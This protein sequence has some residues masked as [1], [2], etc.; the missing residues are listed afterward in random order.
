MIIFLGG[1]CNQSTWRDK[2]I[3]HLAVD[4]FN[5]V[6]EHW[7][8][9]CYERE[10]IAR[11][12]ADFCLFVITPKIEGLFALAEVVDT[13]YKR[14]DRTIYCYLE[15][16]GDESFTEQQLSILEDIGRLVEGNGAVWLK[17]L[18]EIADFF[19]Q[20]SQIKP[21][22]SENDIFDV[23]I[24]YGRRH[25]KEFAVQ[26]RQSLIDQ[27]YKVWLDT[28]NIA[29]AVEFQQKIDEG[30]RYAH[31]FCF[32]LSPHSVNS[33]YCNR[34]LQTALAL[35][36]R[37]IPIH[38]MD[39]GASE[40]DIPEKLQKLNWMM[41]NSNRTYTQTLSMLV[42]ALNQH[43]EVLHPHCELLLHADKWVNS[44]KSHEH[45]LYGQAMSNACNW[46]TN[47]RRAKEL[48]VF[49]LDEH[50]SFINASRLYHQDELSDICVVH[51]SNDQTQVNK[52]CHSL[53][54]RGYVTVTETLDNVQSCSLDKLLY[55]RLRTATFIVVVAS[56]GI[57]HTSAWKYVRDYVQSNQKVSFTLLENLS[58]EKGSD[59]GQIIR[60]DA[61]ANNEE[62]CELLLHHLEQ[63]KD[64]LSLRNN[65]FCRAAQ[66]GERKSDGILLTN[67]ELVDYQQFLAIAQVRSTFG[68]PQSLVDFIEYSAQELEQRVDNCVDIFVCA[69]AEDNHFAHRLKRRLR[70]LE[71]SVHYGDPGYSDQDYALFKEM[72]TSSSRVLVVLPRQASNLVDSLLEMA[73]DLNKPITFIKLKRFREAK[74]DQCYQT[75]CHAAFEVDEQLEV[76]LTQ[77]LAKISG[78]TEYL[79]SYR[80]WSQ[81][82]HFWKEQNNAEE[83][84]LGNTE[85]I[86]ASAW[87]KGALAHANEP[88][89]SE[90]LVQFIDDSRGYVEQAKR[91]ER[92]N[93]TRL[94]VFSVLSLVL[95]CV[96]LLLG[97]NAVKDGKIA[98]AQTLAIQLK[99]TELEKKTEEANKLAKQA[100]LARL[101]AQEKTLLAMA[102]TELANKQKLR[103]ETERENAQKQKDLALILKS[104][105][106]R[107]QRAA[108]SHQAEAQNQADKALR[109]KQIAEIEALIYQAQIQNEGVERITLAVRA[110]KRLLSLNADVRNNILYN[111]L[112]REI[113]PN[114]S[115]IHAHIEPVQHLSFIKEK[116]SLLSIDRSNRFVSHQFTQR[117]GLIKQFEYQLPFKVIQLLSNEQRSVL[118]SEA[119]VVYEINEKEAK[120][121]L[122]RLAS[123]FNAERILTLSG[124]LTWVQS[125]EKILAL[126]PNRERQT[127][128]VINGAGELFVNQDMTYA[129]SHTEGNLILWQLQGEQFHIVWQ[130]PYHSKVTHA[131]F[132]AN[133]LVFVDTNSVFSSYV[134][135]GQNDVRLSRRGKAHEHPISSAFYVA[136]KQQMVSTGV[137]G[138]IKFWPFG[139]NTSNRTPI[140]IQH[141]NWVYS[142]THVEND[143]ASFIYLGTDSGHI[144]PLPL[145]IQY[146]VVQAENIIAKGTNEL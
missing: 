91:S 90:S 89:P 17:S 31:N 85:S 118:L 142:A 87:L 58:P 3:P 134:I 4:Y 37:I 122:V 140:E 41:F 59:L 114:L 57:T 70:E 19:R 35:N 42:F 131:E 75:H 113:K 52:L 88:K 74:Y 64:Y 78:N 120:W 46:L 54:Q 96:S 43:K 130:E 14:T 132:V 144:V 99:N 67:T 26:L 9:Q 44:L 39:M 20:A 110:Y 1:T 60:F 77:L 22:E 119:G 97:V 124:E 112:Y 68:A 11:E 143:D 105:A 125:G 40:G 95:C 53:I 51:H 107:A 33:E 139:V 93:K 15:E 28:E 109:L 47:V 8:E 81:K 137:G 133:R 128:H 38:H 111:L 80:Y 84:L 61:K 117:D 73:S 102:Q 23:F 98:E 32:I 92:R 34:E 18:D 94:K 83:F 116:S 30:I 76:S 63:D 121:E 69:D 50:T 29:I 127:K 100:E 103:A 145:D 146:L 27:G 49:P 24:S 129:F 106:E 65:L 138:T 123:N 2:L 12:T 6:V 56:D 48:E 5:P 16:D 79:E 115:S 135:D 126:Q 55:R 45:L 10:L 101:K 141:S 62:L 25:S 71:K 66:W 82:L 108:L 104:Q 72:M 21:P 7:D 136:S 13:S 86:L 36:K